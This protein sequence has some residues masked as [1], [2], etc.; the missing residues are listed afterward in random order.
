MYPG[1]GGPLHLP[2]FFNHICLDNAEARM[3]RQGLIGLTMA[4]NDVDDV[5]MWFCV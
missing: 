1:L 4:K 3:Q 2:L 5:C